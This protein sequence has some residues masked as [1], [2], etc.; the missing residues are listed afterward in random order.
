MILQ[1]PSV[2]VNSLTDYIYS[3]TFVY[4]LF[5]LLLNLVDKITDGNPLK[6]LGAFIGEQGSTSIGSLWNG[7]TKH[8]RLITT[9][10]SPIWL[11][12]SN[13]FPLTLQASNIILPVSQ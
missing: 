3:L 12:K 1:N 2:T 9:A 4:W 6:K 10:P 13:F 5:F 7:A 11:D 8:E